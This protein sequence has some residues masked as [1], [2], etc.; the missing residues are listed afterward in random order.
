MKIKDAIKKLSLYDSNEEII[1]I[2]NKKGMNND[3]SRRSR[4]DSSSA[5]IGSRVPNLVNSHRD[6]GSCGFGYNSSNKKKW[7]V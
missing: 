2:Q 4:L 1:K 3:N 7:L 6:N 5:S